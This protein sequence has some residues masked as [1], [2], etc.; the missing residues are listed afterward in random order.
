M[1]KI[2]KSV[3]R[4]YHKLK[5]AENKALTSFGL[6]VFTHNRKLKDVL[7]KK[8]VAYGTSKLQKF[9]IIYPTNFKNQKL[10]VV[11]YV[12]GGSWCGGDKYGYTMF[13]QRL[14]KHGYIV[15]NINYRLMPKVSVRTC[16]ADTIK[17]IRYSIHKLNNILK[18]EKINIS[19]NFEKVFMVGD[20]AG[21]HI[22]SLIAAKQTAKKMRLNIK[23]A[24]L[25]LYY[26][27][28]NFE[29]ISHDPSPI[30]TDLDKYWKS[31]YDD[32][33]KIYK[34]ISTTTYITPNFPETFM[35]SGEID[36]LH[37]QS[38]VFSK[39]LKRNDIKLHYLSFKKSRQDARHAF[40]NVSFLSSA[41]EAFA[42][43]IETFEKLR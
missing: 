9:D 22:V 38:Q 5:L 32:P 37:F 4:S 15:V 23:I 39:L 6:R 3:N 11:F 17:A 36:K 14:A 26:G 2:L 40:L 10:P 41:K 8:D 30:M 20:S 25:G 18:K 33:S 42:M 29:N 1:S 28:Y 34:E 24:G 35:T 19:T 12:H 27:V 13:C 21:A 43:L 31:I 7:I 16:I